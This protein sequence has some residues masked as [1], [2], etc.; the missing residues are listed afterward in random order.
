MRLSELLSGIECNINAKNYNVE[1]ENVTTKVDKINSKTLFIII[2][3]INFDTSQ[4]IPDIL[5]K[6]PAAI[7]CDKN[8]NL[9]DTT[10]TVNVKNARLTLAL[11]CS[12]INKI[13]YSKVK[14]VAVTGT[15]GKTSTATMIEK[16]LIYAGEK[17]GFIGTGTIRIGEK[18]FN[19]LNYSMTTPDPE[20]LYPTIKAMIDENC[21]YIIMEVSSHALALGKVSPIFFECAIF[22]NLSDDHLDFHKDKDDYYKTKL[23]LFSMCK[24]G[25]FN[26]DDLYS[27]RAMRD[28]FDMCDTSSVGILWEAEAMA[29]DVMFNGFSGTSYIYREK[30]LMFKA[31]ISIPG[32]H[33]VY[34][35][36]LALKCVIL[37]GIRPCIAKDGLKSI[38]GIDGRFEI[39]EDKITVIRDYAHTESAFQN[40]LKTVNSIKKPGQK[41]FCVFGCGG[42]RDKSKR[43]KMGEAAERYSDEIYLTNDN[44][45]SE[46]ENQ[47]VNDIISGMKNREKAK[48]ILSRKNA[49]KSAILSA[50]DGDIVI[51]L[52]KGHEK[53]ILDKNG[54]RSFDEKEIVLSVLKERN[55]AGAYRNENKA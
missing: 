34:N 53:Y 7:L 19:D 25:I 14:F 15:N 17:V 38:K 4:I 5:N 43:P 16:M 51:I 42:D 36:L 11:L 30:G 23:S 47:I 9:P 20:L 26:A 21:D 48:T 44:P 22:T 41:T 35:S 29:R 28:A 45:R 40:I 54:Y 6:C 1:I 10:L 52:G 8:W 2:D 31:E 46:D 27:A 49:I 55:T 3:G 39:I 24:H 32:Y 33:N 18:T 13:D 37:L 50:R 12:R